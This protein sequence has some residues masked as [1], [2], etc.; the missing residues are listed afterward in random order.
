MRGSLQSLRGLDEGMAGV[1]D[2][3]DVGN[4]VESL[5]L[6]VLAIPRSTG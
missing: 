3:L 1:V 5:L 4:V 2:D 6:A